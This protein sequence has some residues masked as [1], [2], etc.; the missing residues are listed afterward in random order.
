MST[1]PEHKWP[2]CFLLCDNG[3]FQPTQWVFKLFIYHKKKDLFFNPSL[4]LINSKSPNL[5][6]HGQHYLVNDLSK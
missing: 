5:E 1:F 4:Y 2:P 3:N 6:M